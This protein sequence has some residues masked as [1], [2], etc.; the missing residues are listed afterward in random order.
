VGGTSIGAIMGGQCASGW[1]SARMLAE[2]RRALVDAGSLNDFT[3]PIMSLMQGKRFFGMLRQLYGDRSIEDLPIPF[4]C[5]ST[6]LTR[7][8]CMVHRS[9][10]VCKWVAASMAVPGLGPPIF[11]GQ[12]VLVDGGVV[13]NLSL[14]VMRSLGR[15]PVF[16]SSV[17]A[18]VEMRLDREYPD[19]PSP[20]RVLM[21]WINPFST[22]MLVPTIQS[23]LM[24]TVS[25]Q[26]G[27]PTDE[28]DLLFELPQG[29]YKLLD[30]HAFDRIVETGY[31]MAV[32]II[33][34]W[35]SQKSGDPAAV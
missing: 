8:S 1:D 25:L 22:P 4:Y 6:N 21:S 19:L 3:L 23:I 16:A 31:R 26:S 2:S 32:P 17:S 13:N 24:R 14:D 12:D 28:A 35:Q 20:W 7:S 9:G 18:R 29:G 30:W 33:E 5:V 10:P 11:D 34:Q 27:G 15:G